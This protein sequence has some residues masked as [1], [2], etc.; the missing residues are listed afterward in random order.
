MCKP[1]LCATFFGR[2]RI[3][4]FFIRKLGKFCSILGANS[5]T[6]AKKLEKNSDYFMSDIYL[7]NPGSAFISKLK[8]HWFQFYKCSRLE[9][10]WFQFFE[11]N[12]N[13]RFVGSSYFQH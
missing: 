2:D 13:Q 3:V 7:K 11:K 10:D 8:N 1:V 12:Q 6:F 5:T 4:V 9:N